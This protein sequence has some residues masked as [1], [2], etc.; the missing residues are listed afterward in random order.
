M[1]IER[2]RAERTARERAPLSPAIQANPE[3]MWVYDFETLRFLAVN[4]AALRRYGFS[5]RSSWR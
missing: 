4:A 3:A 1:A 2:K 5:K